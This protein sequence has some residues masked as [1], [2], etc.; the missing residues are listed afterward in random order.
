MLPLIEGL[1][2]GLTVTVDDVL[3]EHPLLFITVT[4][5]VPDDV[6]VIDCVVA[7]VDQL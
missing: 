4:L 5:N 6:T 7:P 3:P 1:G 2:R